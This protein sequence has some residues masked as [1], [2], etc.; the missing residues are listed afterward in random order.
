MSETTRVGQWLTDVEPGVGSSSESVTEP[1]EPSNWVLDQTI[2]TGYRCPEPPRGSTMWFT[3]AE[4]GNV[5]IILIQSKPFEA[6]LAV[7]S[8]S[9]PNRLVTLSSGSNRI[10]E[11][12]IFIKV[13]GKEFLATPCF[14]D[15]SIH[16]WDIENY[17]S[18]VV[19]REGSKGNKA[20]RLCVIDDETVGYAEVFP[21]DDVHNVYILNTSTEQWSLRNTLRLRT[22]LQYIW[23]MCY[24]QLT[25][26]TSCLVLCSGGDRKVMAIEM[27]GG[28]IRW[29]IGTKQMGEGF[30]SCSV[31]ADTDHN[32][33]VCDWNQRKI[34]KLSLDD[35]SVI[36]MV[37]TAQQHG[38]GHPRWV[39]M[40]N[41]CLCVSHLNDLRKGKWQIN[42]YKMK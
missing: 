17:T 21:T 18:R 6:D 33:Y 22:G 30:L 14:T 27:L 8:P 40:Y 42:K 24:T 36:S 2:D 7:L 26:G 35:G 16:L 38:F 5:G 4:S 39:Q 15:A 3:V 32:V 28:N 41:D 29:S 9:K 34:D 12:L 13:T 25:D 1:T 37:L 31:C 11:D 20:M 10:Y 19:Y 23:D